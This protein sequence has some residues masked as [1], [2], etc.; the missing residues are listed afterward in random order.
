MDRDRA[1]LYILENIQKELS[2]IRKAIENLQPKGEEN[3]TNQD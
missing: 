2:G 3:D 1:L